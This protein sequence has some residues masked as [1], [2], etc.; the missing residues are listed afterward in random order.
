VWKSGPHEPVGVVAEKSGRPCVVEYS[1]ITT[2]MAERTDDDGRLVFGAGNICNHF[3]T[4][5]FLKDTVLPNLGSLYH[6]ARKKI[7]YYDELT[8]RTVPPE[9]VNGIKLESFIFDI[10][11]WSDRMA[12][13]DAVREDE[14]APVKNAPG[15]LTDSPDTARTY[16]SKRAQ[17]W[18]I[19]A[20]GTLTG[21]QD[22]G[23]CEISPL[24]SYGGEGLEDLVN[25]KEVPCPFTL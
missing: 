4:I 24:I 5:D 12:V 23:T 8:N 1:E 15:S 14:F 11:P 21:N 17:K 19:N 2:E 6:V 20:G 18:V 3:Y 16:L 22:D 10:F 7:P 9:T 13:L 25:G